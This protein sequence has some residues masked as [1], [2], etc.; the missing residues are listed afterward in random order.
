MSYETTLSEETEGVVSALVYR[1]EY[2][3]YLE[4]SH[5]T[6]EEF[7]EEL[8]SK[9]NSV[10]DDMHKDGSLYEYQSQKNAVC[11]YGLDV[12]EIKDYEYD[13]ES[14]LIVV[15]YS[16]EERAE[17]YVC[18]TPMREPDDDYSSIE[19]C[20]DSNEMPHMAEKILDKALTDMGFSDLSIENDEYTEIDWGDLLGQE[21][22]REPDY[23]WGYDD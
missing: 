17:A 16:G 21:E 14:M 23:D 6:P 15:E 20:P 10:F 7:I 12:S 9:L 18:T 22:S 1:N 4:K 3:E 2:N 5:K 8:S 11:L 19:N 13:D